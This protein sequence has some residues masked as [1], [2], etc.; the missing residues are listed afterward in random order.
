MTIILFDIDGTLAVSGQKLTNDMVEILKLL[1]HKNFTLGLVGGGT[2][3]KIKYQ[4]DSAI[5]LFKYIFSECGAVIHINNKLIFEKKM[6]DCCD[7]L[8]LNDI[9]RQAFISISQMPII[10]NGNQIDFRKGLVYI[11]PPG[12]QADIY[13]RNYFLEADQ[14]YNLRQKLLNDLKNIDKDNKFEISFGGSVGIAIH[15]V[16][17]NKSQAVDYLC[18]FTDDSDIYYFGDRTE[19]DGNDYP[20]FIH[21]MI[22]GISVTDYTDTIEKITTYFLKN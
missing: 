18:G 6:T 21:P 3:E 1:H 10:Y 5:N 7:R 4:M 11:S 20:I 22:N 19:P 12:M 15:P 16:G 8:L 9:I 2:Y 17:W 13:E 14:K